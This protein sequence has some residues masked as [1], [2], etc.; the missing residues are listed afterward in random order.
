MVRDGRTAGVSC[1]Q[2]SADLLQSNIPAIKGWTN[3][4]RGL[5]SWRKLP[6]VPGPGA[7]AVSPAG[8]TTSPRPSEPGPRVSS[9]SSDGCARLWFSLWPVQRSTSA[10]GPSGGSSGGQGGPPCIAL[11][12]I[13][14]LHTQPPSPR[15][16]PWSL[17]RERTGQDTQPSLYDGPCRAGAEPGGRGPG[18]PGPHAGE[19]GPGPAGPA[20]SCPC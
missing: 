12:E 6:W 1:G 14:A 17:L 16:R 13:P 3:G 19:G 2:P 4:G 5:G 8:Q 20:V 7:L 10:W 18:F 9:D 15:A 11:W